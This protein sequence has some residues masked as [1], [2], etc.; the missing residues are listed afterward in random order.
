MTSCISPQSSSTCRR[1]AAK[2]ARRID[3]W[4]EKI[5][6]AL[7]AIQEGHPNGTAIHERLVDNGF[8]APSSAI[9]VVHEGFVKPDDWLVF[10]FSV[11]HATARRAAETRRKGAGNE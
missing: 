10:E 2:L 4:N 5:W 6:E 11:V 9:H 1:C 7:R 8:A 3:G